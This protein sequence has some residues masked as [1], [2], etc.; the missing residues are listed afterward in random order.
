VS[1]RKSTN[2][3]DT[4]IRSS[5]AQRRKPKADLYT[6]LLA[7]AL[8]AILI[9]I[10]F[11]CLFMNDYEYKTK[12]APVVETTINRASAVCLTTLPAQPVSCEI[13]NG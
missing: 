12:G 6:F 5:V 9:A 3:L 2:T 4:P 7:L 11:V 10:L 1:P 8:V 13:L